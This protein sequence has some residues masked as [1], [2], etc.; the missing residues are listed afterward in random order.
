MLPLEAIGVLGLLYCFF[1]YAI[2]KVQLERRNISVREEIRKSFVALAN[3]LTAL[4]GS[5]R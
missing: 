4:F 3:A 2:V 1:I 5:F